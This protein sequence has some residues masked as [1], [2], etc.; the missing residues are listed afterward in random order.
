MRNKCCAS[1]K[2]KDLWMMWSDGER[3][4]FLCQILKIK[5]NNHMH[6]TARKKMTEADN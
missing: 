5:Q 2:V 6:I 3:K 1:R 4:E